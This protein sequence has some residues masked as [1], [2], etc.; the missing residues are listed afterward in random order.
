MAQ[1][2]FQTYQVFKYSFTNFQESIVLQIEVRCR[3]LGSLV[4]EL[5]LLRPPY[6]LHVHVEKTKVPVS[7][8][9]LVKS[10]REKCYS[11]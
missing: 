11:P 10:N 3:V 2:V 7:K 4:A 9:P 6:F 8:Q 1:Y 5:F